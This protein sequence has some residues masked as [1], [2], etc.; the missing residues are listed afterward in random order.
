MLDIALQHMKERA[1]VVLCGAMSE[2]EKS[3]PGTGIHHMWEFITKRATAA[4]FMFSNYVEQ[5]PEAI[6]QMAEW[7][8]QG[9]LKSAIELYEGIEETPRAFCDMLSG[10]NRGKC[11]VELQ[12]AGE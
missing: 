10:K 8:T 1:R 11:I 4:G 9:R 7:I 6:R 2:Y 3:G 5:Y 12:D